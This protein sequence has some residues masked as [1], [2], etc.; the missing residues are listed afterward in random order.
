MSKFRVAT[1]MSLFTLLF[2]L[3]PVA[4]AASA[5]PMLLT[6]LM[7]QP[8]SQYYHYVYGGQLDLARKNDVA[9]LRLQYLERPAFRN[10]GYV[11]QDFSAAAMFGKSVL[12]IGN[13][14]VNALVGGGYAWGYIK[15]DADVAPRREAYRLPGIATSLEAKWG[16]NNIDFRLAHQMMICQSSKVQAEAYVAWPFTWFIFSMSTPISIGG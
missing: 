15:D 1:L 10:A 6:G 2:G 11:D 16:T 7:Q 14:G 4:L 3:E 9:M 8:S 5:R 13:I 12:R